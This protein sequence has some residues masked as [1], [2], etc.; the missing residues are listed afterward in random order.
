[1]SGDYKLTKT[2]VPKYDTDTWRTP[3]SLYANFNKEFDFKLDA[4]CDSFNCLAPSGLMID[5]GTNSLTL[6]WKSCLDYASDWIWLNPPFRS[7]KLWVKKAAESDCNVVCLVQAD[8][9]TIWWHRYAVLAY[10]IRFYEGRTRFDP[11]AG[12]IVGVNGSASPTKPTAALVFCPEKRVFL[13]DPIT[14][15]ISRERNK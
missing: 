14:R 7:V 1:M 5:F 9:G 2:Q 4:A 6:D 12:R 11:P 8:T 13:S 15:Y 3:I 10:E